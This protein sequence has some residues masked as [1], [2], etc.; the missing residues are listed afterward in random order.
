[1][2]KSGEDNLRQ[3][4]VQTVE[5]TGREDHQTVEIVSTK[6]D[7]IPSP[8]GHNHGSSKVKLKNIVDFTWEHRYYV[9]Q[10]LAVHMSGKYLA[11]GIKAGN[12]NG[13]V[14]VVNKELE[15]RTLIRGMRGLIQ[16]LAFAHVSNPIL[17]C[18]DYT[19]S[20]FVYSIEATSSELIC[21][22]VLQVDAD[23]PSPMSHRVIWCPYI[24]EEEATDGD[25]VSKLLAL[26]RGSKAE[27]WSIAAASRLFNTAIKATDPEIKE[28]SVMLE[29]YQHS[30]TIVEATFSPDGTALATA[31]SDGEVKFF[32]VYLH[33][34]TCGQQP[35]RCLHQWRP[36]DGK[37]ISSLFFLDDHKNY[38]PDAQFWRFAVTGCDNNS[39][40]KVWSCELWTCLQTIKFS[41]M[42][43][44]QKTP[45]LKARLDLAASY[46][47]LSDIYNKVLY[48]LSISKDS[49]EAVACIT[50]VSEFL[51]PYP[52]LSFAIVDAGQRRLK[53]TSESLEDLCPC[54]DENE[55]QLVIRM[56]LVQPK[57][58]QECHIAFRPPMQMSG[59]CLMDTLTHDSL[60]YSED[61]LDIG[62]I[63][64]NSIIVGVNDDDEGENGEEDA[65]IT[66]AV[67]LTNHTAQLN[68]MTPD[69]FSS[70]AKK[71]SALDSKSSS[72]QLGNIE[73]A[74]PSIA[75]TVQALNAA[76][77]PL[78]TSKLEEQAPPSGGSSP[79]R[80]VCEILSLAEPEESETDA[81]PEPTTANNE[82]WS[83]I[84]MCLIKD[85]IHAMQE[86]GKEDVADGQ[87][88]IKKEPSPVLVVPEDT[89]SKWNFTND[90]YAITNKL[91][92]VLELI[93]DQ[94][95]EI[96]E[97]R[98][99][100][101]RLRQETPLTNRV[102]SALAK[103][104]QQQNANIEQTLSNQVTQQREFLNSLEVAVK[105]N[106]EK[107]IPMVVQDIVEPLKRQL[108]IDASQ[109]D[110]I[111]KDNM[112]KMLGGPQVREA[113]SV[114]AA[115]AA[116]P[117]LEH[118][119]REAFTGI[120]MPGMEK[121]CQNMFKQVQDAF[122][123]GT[124]EYL[125][126][127]D[128]IM[129]KQYQRQNKQQSEAL[130]NA[131]REEMQNE[132][133][134]GLSMMQE[135]TIRSVRDSVRENFTQH[136]SDISGIRSRA[137]TPGLPGPTV[138]DAQA[139]VMSLL[140]R[141]QLNAAF[142]QALSASDLGLVVL[143]CDNTDPARVFSASMGPGQG[144]RCVLQQPVLLSLVQQLSANL[145]HR[146]ELKHRW[147]EEAVI[148]L[149]PSDPVTREHMLT[150]LLT[151]QNQV[152]AF[153]TANP[154]H[155]SV[156]RL[157]MVAMAAHALLKPS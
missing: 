4:Y 138:A 11:Y 142:Q 30:G 101:T 61:P 100:V 71:E 68:L 130:A 87:L 141:G 25:E 137:T 10:L 116:R 23:D 55:D 43:N 56:Y 110:G 119:F 40:L 90:I 50:T 54:D 51:L 108:R 123:I 157:K 27:L 19:G 49:E 135:N 115:N 156:R 114:A 47:L 31:S 73:S 96:S 36:H 22:R 13:V 134:R 92:S 60:V 66:E 140:Q 65:N 154:N 67:E 105:E 41:P 136:M 122:L 44:T 125:Q 112:T 59:N 139:R 77:Q 148:S 42:P 144:S 18:V 86:Q 3:Q 74:S 155:R 118:A 58:L 69:A 129:D 81:K 113:V 28:N 53:P 7:V 52:I 98:I 150:V 126:N 26:T 152:A 95:Q 38:H 35:P 91:D 1:M 131:V 149:D 63:S 97:L 6:V 24:P 64:Y 103:A 75:Q 146:T 78:A 83:Q 16:D 46:L 132:F 117:A 39:E 143:V 124:R 17:A 82:N 104:T 29:I 5:F 48:I 99:E 45:V 8:G 133:S 20:L 147:L 72:P 94:Q 32:Q 89:Q 12:G 106:I 70:P 2:I 93:Q 21:S 120:L 107:T 85:A 102:E 128:S 88:N 57:S 62:A 121:A 37:P 145:G 109:I 76:D 15:Q 153:I 111:V 80:E 84:P 9:G 33:G 34:A 151:L 127:V 79:S 14:R